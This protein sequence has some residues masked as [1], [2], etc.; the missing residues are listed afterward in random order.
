[1][2]KETNPNDPADT[3][4]C[5][6]SCQFCM[7]ATARGYSCLRRC[8]GERAIPQRNSDGRQLRA[9]H[10]ELGIELCGPGRRP[11][12]HRHEMV[13]HVELGPALLRE[14]DPVG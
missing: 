13:D 12:G 14:H 1:M 9:N 11:F 10:V 6:I 8:S 7:G 2:F 5:S 3:H 4:A